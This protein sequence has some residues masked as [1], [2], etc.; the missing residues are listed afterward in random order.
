[1]IM[2]MRN[3]LDNLSSLDA[4]ITALVNLD[5]VCETIEEEYLASLRKGKFEMWEEKS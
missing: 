2:L 5:T 1:M 3:V 4:L